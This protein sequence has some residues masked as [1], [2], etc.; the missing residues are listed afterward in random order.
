MTTPVRI[1]VAPSVSPTRMGSQE[2]GSP[3]GSIGPQEV[4]DAQPFENSINGI[5]TKHKNPAPT[6]SNVFSRKLSDESSANVS[7]HFH[8]NLTCDAILI[9]SPNFMN[10]EL[11]SVHTSDEPGSVFIP[12]TIIRRQKDRSNWL[13][14]GHLIGEVIAEIMSRTRLEKNYCA[15]TDFETRWEDQD[16]GR[17][18]N[19]MSR[20]PLNSTPL[21]KKNY[22][23]NNVTN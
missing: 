11:L 20:P 23:Q 7:L 8:I 22:Q 10:M 16:L 1:G 18:N 13:P 9:K 21:G 6:F 5:Y 12:S 14:P 19:S 3:S 15:K 2:I 17:Q 4:R